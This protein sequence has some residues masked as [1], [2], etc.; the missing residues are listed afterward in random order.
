MEYVWVTLTLQLSEDN[1]FQTLGSSSNQPFTN[2]GKAFPLKS[3][4]H[5]SVM[6]QG[7]EGST[8]LPY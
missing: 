7:A 8:Y 3:L 1:D 2:Q 6:T 4:D 5:Y